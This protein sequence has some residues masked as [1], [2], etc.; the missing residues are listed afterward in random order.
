MEEDMAAAA[1]DRTM[2]RPLLLEYW[3]A[4]AS[5]KGQWKKGHGRTT[6]PSPPFPP[7]PPLP[8]QGN[9]DKVQHEYRQSKPKRETILAHPSHPSQRPEKKKVESIHCGAGRAA[10][11][12]GMN[13]AQG[14]GLLAL[15][16]LRY[17]TYTPGFSLFCNRTI[18]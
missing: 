12:M 3:A 5:E 13:T 15:L 10:W 9:S 8:S 1:P 18:L 2:A 6:G 16:C 11:V 14:S 17:R 7:S 4:Q